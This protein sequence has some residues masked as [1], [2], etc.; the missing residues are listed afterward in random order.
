MSVGSAPG[1]GLTGVGWGGKGARG[2]S[3]WRLCVS[4]YLAVQSGKVLLRKN[5]GAVQSVAAVFQQAEL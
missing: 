2:K 4:E 1:S 5:F 3:C